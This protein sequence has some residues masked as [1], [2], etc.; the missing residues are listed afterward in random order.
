[1]KQKQGKGQVILQMGVGGV[2]V[3]GTLQGAQTLAFQQV[4]GT[5]HAAGV[6]EHST[7]TK[8]PGA[9]HQVR[10]LRRCPLT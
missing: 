3:G 1:M 6:P 2:G 7:G 5:L 9:R 4:P 8:L 10:F